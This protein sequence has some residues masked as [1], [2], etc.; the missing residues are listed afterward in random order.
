[1][2]IPRIGCSVFYPVHLVPW[3]FQTARHHPSVVTQQKIQ[4]VSS[5]VESGSDFTRLFSSVPIYRY[6]RFTCDL[7]GEQIERSFFNKHSGGRENPQKANRFEIGQQQQ[8]Q[9]L[10]IVGS[11]DPCEYNAAQ[12]LSICIAE[13]IC[14]HHHHQSCRV[15]VAGVCGFVVVSLLVAVLC[16]WDNIVEFH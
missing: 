13:H 4:K 8:R 12:R 6:V 10:P 1:M 2:S 7:R 15:C 5:V 14:N 16:S 11:F 3:N 9:N